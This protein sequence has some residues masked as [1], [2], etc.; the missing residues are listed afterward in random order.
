MFKSAARTPGT[1]ANVIYG[2]GGECNL[3]W[4]TNRYTRNFVR[5]SL[6]AQKMS[7]IIRD[8]RMVIGEWDK[9]L[10][11]TSEEC[12][13]QVPKWRCHQKVRARLLQI[14]QKKSALKAAKEMSLSQMA[15]IHELLPKSMPKRIKVEGDIGELDPGGAGGES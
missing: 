5:S 7:K 4:S 14:S 12:E 10:L 15:L 9:S 8:T 6:F 2:T 11:V 13:S 3:L 1:F